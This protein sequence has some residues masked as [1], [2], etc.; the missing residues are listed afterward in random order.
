MKKT[1]L[2]NWRVVITVSSRDEG[3]EIKRQVLRHCDVGRHDVSLDWDVRVFCSFCGYD[4]EED[5][6]GPVCCTAAQNEWTMKRD[7]PPPS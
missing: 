2:E 1:A 6:D 7:G 3:E 5:S 4:P